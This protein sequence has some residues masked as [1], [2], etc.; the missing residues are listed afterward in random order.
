MLGMDVGLVDGPVGVARHGRG[1]GRDS[2]PEVGDVGVELV[3]RLGAVGPGRTG[4][5]DG[6]RA[7][8]GLDVVGGIA[9]VGPEVGGDARLSPEVRERRTRA[10]LPIVG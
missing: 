3:D 10:R 9:Q 8:K 1:I 6:E 4:A 5:Q 7:G 2:A